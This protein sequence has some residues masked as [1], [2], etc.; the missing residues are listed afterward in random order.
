MPQTAAA[1]GVHLSPIYRLADLIHS[2]TALRHGIDNTPPAHLL[3]N[4][5]RL[6]AGLEDITAL[7]GHRLVLSSGYRCP[8]LNIRVGGSPTSQHT[9]GEA[10]DFTCPDFGNPIAV[11]LALHHSTI[12]FDQCILEFDRWVHVS[13]GTTPRRRTLTIHSTSAGYLD[14][15]HSATGEQLA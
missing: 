9:Q 5:R 1:A 4:L 8:A 10:A 15:L 3:V 11:A 14:G 12:Q 2:D 6:A 13:F 7:L